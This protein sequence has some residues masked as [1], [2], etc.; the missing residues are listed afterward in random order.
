MP[1][2]GATAPGNYGI[3]GSSGAIYP[4]DYNEAGS[5]LGPHG[6][7]RGQFLQLWLRSGTSQ[8]LR[9]FYAQVLRS[10][11]AHQLSYSRSALRPHLPPATRTY[12][13]AIPDQFRADTFIE[14]FEE[15]WIGEG[16]TLPQVLTIILPNDHGAG[17]RPDAGYP[18]RE[19]Y[20]AD[21][22]LALGRV[23]EHLSHTP[24][25]KNMAIFVTEDDSQDGVDHI[26]AHRSLLMVYSPY[27]KRDYVGHQHYSFGSIFK[28]FWNIPGHPLPKPLRR[29][30]PPT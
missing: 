12:N 30:G 20:M 17:D 18:F 29:R 14:E 10:T 2:P 24:Y 7:E 8:Q 13:M 19:S 1:F 27:A 11:S 22:D 28:T 9:R 3:V 5:Y 23:V 6:P 26:D 4:E 16:Q 25:W 21:N 15:K